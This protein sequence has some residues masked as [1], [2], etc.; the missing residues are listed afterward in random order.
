MKTF[1]VGS[2]NFIGRLRAKKNGGL[3]PGLSP[4]QALGLGWKVDLDAL[5]H[6]LRNQLKQGKVDL[7]DP[8]TTLALLKLDAVVGVKG[9]FTA[10]NRTP[11]GTRNPAADQIT[12][13]LP[14]LHFYQLSLPAPKPRTGVDFEKHDIENLPPIF[15]NP[16]NVLYICTFRKSVL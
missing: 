2:S 7:A 8:A 11:L 6:P 1:G 9:F 12:A 5:P 10:S 4:T 13:K 14:A 3:G 16:G 15:G